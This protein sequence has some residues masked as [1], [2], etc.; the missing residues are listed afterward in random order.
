MSWKY[1]KTRGHNLLVLRAQL[2]S[3][4]LPMHIEETFVHYVVNAQL[5]DSFTSASA[6][7]A[8]LKSLHQGLQL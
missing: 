4:T 6:V 7:D 3:I 5:V 1:L 2:T 8:L